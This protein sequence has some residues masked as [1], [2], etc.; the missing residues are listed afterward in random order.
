MKRLLSE[1]PIGCLLSG[2]L[3][4]SLVA[5]IVQ[6]EMKK[7]GKRVNT[8]SIGFKGSPDLENARVVAKH[9]G[10][11][12]HEV[13]MNFKDIEKR[14]PEIIMQLET[15]DTT[16][17]RAS[18]GMFLLSEYISQKMEDVVIFSGEGADELCQGYLYFHRQPSP[19][20]GANAHGRA[21]AKKPQHVERP[22]ARPVVRNHT[23]QNARLLRRAVA[24]REPDGRPRKSLMNLPASTSKSRS[25]PVSM[26]MP[27]SM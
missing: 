9:I 22:R 3:D 25:M 26:P 1:R 15:W 2:G 23:C 24:T 12:H 4:S 6:E 19:A 7:N 13:I 16:T 17:I 18:I 11:N 8:Y 5:A 27:C 10:S 20:S 14:I 21:A